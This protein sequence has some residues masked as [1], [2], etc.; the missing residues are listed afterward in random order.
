MVVVYVSDFS[1]GHNSVIKLVKAEMNFLAISV[2][3]MFNL[4]KKMAHFLE[5]S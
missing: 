3:D 4:L 5:L 2:S 1:T